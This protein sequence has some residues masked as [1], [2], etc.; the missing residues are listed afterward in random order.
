MKSPDKALIESIRANYAWDTYG[1]WWNH[2]ARVRQTVIEDMTAARI[3]D[4]RRKWAE[5]TVAKL[6]N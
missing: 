5:R 2:Y 1:L 3:K 4:R 6:F